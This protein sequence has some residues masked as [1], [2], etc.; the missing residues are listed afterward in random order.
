[1]HLN[2]GSHKLNVSADGSLYLLTALDPLLLAL[3]YLEAARNQV[4]SIKLIK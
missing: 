2:A 1:M 3:P 4:E